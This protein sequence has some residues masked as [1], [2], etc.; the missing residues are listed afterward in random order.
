MLPCNKQGIVEAPG[1]IR[2]A[3]KEKNVED[4]LKEPGKLERL[5]KV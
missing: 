4:A 2:A 5:L 3:L 1:T